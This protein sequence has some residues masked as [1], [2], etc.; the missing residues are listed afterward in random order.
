MT[1]NDFYLNSMPS[2]I[3]YCCLLL[4][5]SHTGA[6]LNVFFAT[7]AECNSTTRIVLHKLR[8]DDDYSVAPECGRR[9]RLQRVRPVPQAARRQPAIG[10]AQGRHPDAQTQA[11]E[12]LGRRRC[13]C[14]RGGG[15]R[16]QSLESSE[17]S[18]HRAPARDERSRRIGQSRSPQ[19]LVL[20]ESLDREH[21]RH[22]N[23]SRAIGTA[24][25]TVRK[26]LVAIS[27]CFS[28]NGN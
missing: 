4:T 19:R 23:R 17:R 9:A 1:S 18:L 16:G 22:Q 5:A 3:C 15:R 24:P 12:Q 13:G 20:F 14:G 25:K 28:T 21:W 27:S 6:S 26:R 10:N 7:Q 8:N 2:Y 11:Q